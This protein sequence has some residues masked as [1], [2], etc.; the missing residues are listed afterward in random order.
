MQDTRRLTR[1]AVHILIQ[2]TSLQ[3]SDKMTEEETGRE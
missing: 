1:V 3:V 2:A